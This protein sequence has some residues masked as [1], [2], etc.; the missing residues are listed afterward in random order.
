MPQYGLPQQIQPEI[1]QLRR[2][3][4]S[5]GVSIRVAFIQELFGDLSPALRSTGFTLSTLETLMLC[6]PATLRIPMVIPELD[7]KTVTDTSPIEDVQ[8]A[9]DINERGFDPTYDQHASIEEAERFRQTL[10]TARAFVARFNGIAV[11]G[12]MYQSPHQGITRLDGIATIEPYRR[13]GIAA[14]L[15]ASMTQAAFSAGAT[16]TFLCAVRD[17]AERVYA[18]TGYQRVGTLATF[19]DEG[20]ASTMALD[21]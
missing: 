15:T 14:L 13:R 6:S 18:R 2:T 12:G 11:A 4:G 16:L 20:H 9:L 17:L 5:T 1:E 8:L 10:T 7:V 21:R 19:V 3:I